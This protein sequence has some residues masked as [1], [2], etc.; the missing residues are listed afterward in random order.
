MGPSRAGLG[1]TVQT[2]AFLAALL[3]KTGQPALD[4]RPAP[5]STR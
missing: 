1:K 5:A 4:A 3:G 2:I